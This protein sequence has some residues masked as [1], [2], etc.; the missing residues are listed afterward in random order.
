[1]ANELTLNLGLGYAKNS[2]TVERSVAN[3]SRTVNG[4][5]LVS[6]TAYIAPTAETPIPLGSITVPGGYLSLQNNDPT[7]FV[8][9]R[10]QM[11]GEIISKML[12]GDIVEFRMPDTSPIVVPSTQCDTAPCPLS[13]AAFDK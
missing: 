6:L 3:L 7:N 2:T 10:T 9:L 1:M 13:L 8:T 5:G 12:P 11:G 4:N